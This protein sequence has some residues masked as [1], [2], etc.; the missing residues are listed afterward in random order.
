MYTKILLNNPP[1]S[2]RLSNDIMVRELKSN[3]DW[4]LMYSHLEFGNDYI[5]WI[6]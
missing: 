6:S 5:S 3:N 2:Y 1:T 4:D